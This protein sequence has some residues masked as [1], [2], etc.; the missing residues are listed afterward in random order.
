MHFNEDRNNMIEPDEMEQFELLEKKIDSLIELV[1]ELKKERKLLTEKIQIQDEK[2]A[3][4][5]EQVNNLKTIRD[6]AKNKIAS[7]L[8]KME[9]IDV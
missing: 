3:D 1:N 6:K 4:L 5:T 2:V 8:E 9:Q 7:I